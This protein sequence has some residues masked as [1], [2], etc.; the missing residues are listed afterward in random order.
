MRE[1][2]VHHR[3]ELR[4]R[5]LVADRDRLTGPVAA[6]HHER[7]GEIAQQEV[8]QWAVRKEDPDVQTTDA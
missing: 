5:F 7:T 1:D 3:S 4:L 2:A 6:G 8:V